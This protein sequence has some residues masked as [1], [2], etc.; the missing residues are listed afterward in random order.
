MKMREIK[1]NPIDKA[2]MV[3]V[4]ATLAEPVPNKVEKENAIRILAEIITRHVHLRPMPLDFLA[5]EIAKIARRNGA[6]DPFEDIYRRIVVRLASHIQAICLLTDN[7][8]D[9]G[10]FDLERVPEKPRRIREDDSR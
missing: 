3:D 10:E 2:N 7:T 1:L 8:C 9:D 6:D 5:Q 4:A